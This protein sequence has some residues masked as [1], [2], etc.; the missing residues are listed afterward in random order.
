M[1]LCQCIL[2]CI[3]NVEILM[4]DICQMIYMAALLI[5]YMQSCRSFEQRAFSKSSVQ[6]YMCTCA[7]VAFAQSLGN[8]ALTATQKPQ[9]NKANKEAT[10]GEAQC[11]A[12]LFLAILCTLSNVP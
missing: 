9:C 4:Y 12:C 7:S 10:G 3:I 5:S 11:H 2:V 6:I 1:H 8:S